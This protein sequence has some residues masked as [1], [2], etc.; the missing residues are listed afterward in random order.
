MPGKTTLKT[1]ATLILL[2][3]AVLLFR[4]WLESH[5]DQLQLKATLE[6]Q[7]NS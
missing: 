2:A 3:V 6:A 5:E 4:S 1:L 7:N